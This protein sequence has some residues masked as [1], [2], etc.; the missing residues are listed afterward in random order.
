MSAKLPSTAQAQV[1]IWIGNH[2]ERQGKICL[3]NKKPVYIASMDEDK[4]IRFCNG[5]AISKR[6]LDVFKEHDFSP[7]IIYTRDDMNT[8]YTTTRSMFTTM[9]ILRDMGRP[10][11]KH[12]QWILPLAYWNVEQGHVTVPRDYPT[13]DISEWADLLT[14]NVEDF[15][16]PNGV[17]WEALRRKFHPDEESVVAPAAETA[18]RN[19]VVSAAGIGGLN[20]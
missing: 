11:H 17:K 16:I 6:I 12:S 5:Y 7:K 4:V 20:G 18:T 10:G 9:G 3:L 13:M 1:G 8:Y 15:S 2:F 19:S 14:H